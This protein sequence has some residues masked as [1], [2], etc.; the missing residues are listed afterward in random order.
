[1]GFPI[2]K[3]GRKRN[4]ALVGDPFDILKGFFPRGV[5]WSKS[6]S[7]SKRDK[8]SDQRLLF[9]SFFPFSFPSPEICLQIFF[10][11]NSIA[12]VTFYVE[13]HNQDLAT[14]LLRSFFKFNPSER[15]STSHLFFL[16]VWGSPTEDFTFRVHQEDVVTFNWF[17]KPRES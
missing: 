4:C 16:Q 13:L 9:F 15:S 6:N 12:G 10:G 5:G 3:F 7:N 1:M 14:I 17:V 8:V 2:S 11:K